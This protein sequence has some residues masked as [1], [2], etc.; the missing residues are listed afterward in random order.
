MATAASVTIAGPPGVRLYGGRLAPAVLTGAV[1]AA[2]AVASGSLASTA[3]AV[4]T[5]SVTA[6]DATPSGTIYSGAAPVAADAPATL[7]NETGTSGVRFSAGMAFREGDV[8]DGLQLTC[9]ALTAFQGV[10][11]NRWPDGSVK[12]AVVAGQGSVTPASSATIDITG[13]AGSPGSPVAE[14]V[15]ITAAPQA[16]IGFSG[17]GTVALADLLG[18]ASTLSGGRY[19]AGRVR[20]LWE[21]PLCSSWLYYSRIAGHE[22]LAAWFEVR[23]WADGVYEVLPWIENGWWNVAGP[24]A[25]TGTASFSLGGVEQVSAAMTVHHHQR[26]ALVGSNAEPYRVGGNWATLLHDPEYLQDTELVPSYHAAPSEAKLGTLGQTYTPG[27]AGSSDNSTI[28]NTMGSGGY[29]PSIGVLPE[30]DAAY[31]SSADQRA[32]RCVM[33]NGFIYGRFAIHYRDESTNKF[34]APGAYPSW[35]ISGSS[36]NS[37]MTDVSASATGSYTPTVV[38]T[39]PSYFFAHT[40]HPSGGYM[41]YLASGWNYH[42]ETTQ[43]IAAV[44]CYRMNS[45]HRQDDKHLFRGDVTAAMRG[46]AWSTRSVAQAAA[47]TPD[48]DSVQAAHLGVLHANIDFNHATYV[49]QPNNRFG[50]MADQDAYTPAASGVSLAGSTATVVQLGLNAVPTPA[51][52]YVGWVL[53]IGGEARNVINYPADTR[54]ATVDVPFTVP[55]SEVPWSLSDEKQV[56]PIWQHDFATAAHGYLL[57]IAPLSSDARQKQTE[58]FHWKA[59][60]VVGRLGT[61]G[62]VTSYHYCDAGIFEL[63]GH[64][65]DNP[66]VNAGTGPFYANWGQIYEQTLLASNTAVSGDVIRGGSWPAVTGSW[67]NLM[68]AIAYALR[69]GVVDADVGYGRI[70]SDPDWPT[71]LANLATSP[72]WGIKPK[73]LPLP[74]WVPAVGAVADVSTNRI[75]DIDPG[76]A[77]SREGDWTMQGAVSLFT[78]WIGMHWQDWPSR[79][80]FEGN[81]HADGCLNDVYH[82]SRLN[83]LFSIIK[84]RN[85]YSVVPNA[86]GMRTWASGNTGTQVKLEPRFS[87]A[88][89]DFYVGWTLTIGGE[90][91]VITGYVGATRVAT[92]GTAFTVTVNGVPYRLTNGGTEIGMRVVAGAT[93]SVIRLE[94]TDPGTSAPNNAPTFSSTNGIYYLWRLWIGNE[95]RVV[96]AYVG[97][98]KEF[99]LTSAFG[100]APAE[101]TPAIVETT[102]YVAD[103]VT[104]WMWSDKG[105]VDVDVG[106]PFGAHTYAEQLAVPGDAIPGGDLRGWLLTVGRQAMPIAA[107]RPTLQS[108]ALR[109]GDPKWIAY[110][111]PMPSAP[112]R[113]PTFY[114]RARNRAISYT[115][116]NSSTKHFIDL[117]TGATG[118]FSLGSTVYGDSA[119]GGYFEAEDLYMMLRMPSTGAGDPPFA[120]AVHD[121]R[122]GYANMPVTFAG[123]QPAL[124][125]TGGH[126]YAVRWF[127]PW[128]SFICYAANGAAAIHF[129]KAPANPRVSN[130]W[131]WV[132]RSI[133]GV[134]RSHFSA[135][136]N[137]PPYN[138]IAGMRE[139]AYGR[140]TAPIMWFPL[141]NQPAQCFHVERP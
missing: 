67:A 54:T 139:Y 133:T 61:P 100:A 108:H 32:R 48:G 1:A 8:P 39:G 69:H 31:V 114:D 105:G 118:S 17:V 64:P 99:T 140:N 116:A 137:N 58:F 88:V 33:V 5:G 82:W 110:G 57:C 119:I 60:S 77:Q 14:S 28:A 63:V 41:A 10:V 131:T 21:G 50:F 6:A 43:T 30:W 59:R 46:V 56:I 19:T 3:P 23:C 62:V 27:A 125:S 65:A 34:V 72:V 76:N 92:V 107:N 97:A 90:A 113:G 18:V 101:G 40:H 75:S 38:G 138:R 52:R 26:V 80:S 22:H 122:N 121:V 24:T 29:S 71:F 124:N 130:V 15:L 13:S 49:A 66:N 129:L 84:P 103:M 25:A 96:Q 70:L 91:R 16:V 86:L 115:N 12:F 141:V 51:G 42:I 9:A 45:T 81:G 98:T 117:T 112:Q 135:P 127:E 123:T 94:A 2:D 53:T 136:T 83:N 37:G 104:G 68:P 93:A 36:G 132:E 134:A 120:F 11:L 78:A 4:L 35:V 95:F 126:H 79:A 73:P 44:C 74:S 106:E 7:L 89:D 85:G 109:P 20:T 47:L 128:R 87:S 55:T 111:N 102:G